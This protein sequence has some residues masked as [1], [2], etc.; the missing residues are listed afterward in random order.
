MRECQKNGLKI[1]ANLSIIG[2]DNIFG[3]DFTSP[4]LTTIEMNLDRVG[5][6]A[7]TA[8]LTALE[9]IDGD[10]NDVGDHDTNLVVR[11]STGKASLR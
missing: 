9:V 2:F 8:T 11:N 6:E 7:V 4:A 5:A 10:S 1:P 3:S